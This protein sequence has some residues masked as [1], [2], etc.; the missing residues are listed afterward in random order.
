MTHRVRGSLLVSLGAVAFVLL[1]ACLN[2]ANLLLSRATGRSREIAV[3]SALGAGRMRVVRQMLTESLL[4]AFLGGA[5]GLLLGAWGA[6]ALTALFP[7]R[8]PVPRL[9][10]TRLDGPGFLV[11]AGHL[12]GLGN[13]LLASSPPCRQPAA[14]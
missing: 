10:Q 11:Y 6:H 3:R 13:R 12:S 14:T 5:A 1:I 4:L 2:V 7:D 9:D 8:I